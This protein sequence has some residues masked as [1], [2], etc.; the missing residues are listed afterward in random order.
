MVI[1]A[2]RFTLGA[3]CGGRLVLV[4]EPAK[5]IGEFVCELSVIPHKGLTL[6][7]RGRPEA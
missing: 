1:F 5:L 4:G 6:R 3:L 7:N 2:D